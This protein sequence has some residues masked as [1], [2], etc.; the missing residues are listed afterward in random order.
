MASITKYLQCCCHPTTNETTTTTEQ[1]KTNTH[2]HTRPKTKPNVTRSESTRKQ[3]PTVSANPHL[4]EEGRRMKRKRKWNNITHATHLKFKASEVQFTVTAQQIQNTLNENLSQLGS[5]LAK[6]GTEWG[7]GER[8][9]TEQLSQFHHPI[10]RRPPFNVWSI[11]TISEVWY[12]LF[13]SIL[14]HDSVMCLQSWHQ[15]PRKI[16]RL[17]RRRFRLSFFPGSHH[18]PWQLNYTKYLWK[19]SQHQVS[20]FKQQNS[21]YAHNNSN[22]TNTA[23]KPIKNNF[24]LPSW[25]L[26][27]ICQQ[28]QVLNA[29]KNV[30]LAI[31]IERHMTTKRT[32]NN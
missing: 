11:L 20:Y 32:S 29:F 22:M 6:I 21:R 19:H 16:F 9:S 4:R 8:R 28:L 18:V 10:D 14:W 7:S 2:T 12:V 3:R 27:Q 31:V 25:C 13:E 24:N 26:P 5:G 23:I 17:V 15:I 1:N 30:A